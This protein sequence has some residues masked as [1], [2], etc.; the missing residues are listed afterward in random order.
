VTV[1]RGNDR[2]QSDTLDYVGADQV[3]LMRGRV[4]VRL[5]TR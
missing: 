2:L 5:S 3:A 4:K 1:L